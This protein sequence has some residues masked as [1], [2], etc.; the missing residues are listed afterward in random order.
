MSFAEIQAMQRV[1]ETASTRDRRSLRQIQEEERART[2]EEQFLRWWAEE[3]ERVRLEQL[4]TASPA[5]ARDGGAEGKQNEKDGKG[6]RRRPPA[7]GQNKP[8]PKEK[9]QA[10]TQANVSVITE[11]GGGTNAVM[12]GPSD[13]PARGTHRRPKPKASK[14]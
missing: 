5:R 9:V 14:H 8:R 3:E 13:G 11:G 2:E 4:V 10:G 6:G 1:Q 7:A 12:A